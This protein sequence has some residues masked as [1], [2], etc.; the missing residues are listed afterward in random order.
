[1]FITDGGL[2]DANRILTD[3]HKHA[4]NEAN[5]SRDIEE[6]VIR[7]LSGL[8]NDLNAK[9][10]EIK[11]LGGDFKNS[12]EKEK[13][14]TKRSISALGDALQHFDHG[15]TADQPKSDPFIVRLGVDRQVERQID[16]E[17]YLHRVRALINMID[18]IANIVLSRHTSTSKTPVENSRLSSSERSRSLSTPSLASSV[19]RQM[20]LTTLSS[21]CALAQ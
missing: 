17:N 6:D 11:S 14:G 18:L 16:E 15:A 10:K 5:K 19:V 9:I 2:G 1:M 7:A 21:S 13:E 3:Y 8:R 12:V 4:L 20:T